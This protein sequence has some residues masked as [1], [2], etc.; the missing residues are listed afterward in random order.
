MLPE[1]SSGPSQ[2]W[3][4][5]QLPSGLAPADLHTQVCQRLSVLD[6][7]ERTIAKERS[8]LCTA[9]NHS[10]LVNRL[11][12]ELLV[13]IFVHV[14]DAISNS[15]SHLYSNR[16]YPTTKWTKVIKVCRH[17]RDVAYSSPVLWRAILMR[18]TVYT[19]LS[20]FKSASQVESFEI[21]KTKVW[22]RFD[23]LD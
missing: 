7:A 13:F 17:W 6:A 23:F 3:E 19:Q 10:L 9:W 22:I 16:S 12:S 15:E 20:V 4:P 18:S 8:E 1:N 11:P 5:L 14:S 21:T 2:H